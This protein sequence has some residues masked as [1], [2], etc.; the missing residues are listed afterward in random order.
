MNERFEVLLSR[1]RKQANLTNDELAELAVVPRS[2]IP[3]LQSGKRRIGEHQ[4]RKIGA[5]LGLDGQGLERFVFSAINNCTEKVLKESRAYPAEL[6]NLAARQLKAAGIEPEQVVGCVVSQEGDD[7]EV[8]ILLR[9]GG[10]ARLETK[11]EVT[12]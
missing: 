7:S 11:L 6:L 1:L 4:A 8:A 3:G 12:A 10:E 9:D 5:A 2:L